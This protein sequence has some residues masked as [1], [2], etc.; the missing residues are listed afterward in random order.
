MTRSERT[1]ERTMNDFTEGTFSIRVRASDG[2]V[3]LAWSGKSTS[4]YPDRTLT[5]YLEEVIAEAHRA[6]QSLEIDLSAVEYVNSST[7]AAIIRALG[8]S[9]LR[10][11]HVVV[12]YDTSVASQKRNFDALR[13]LED[14]EL[15][16]SFRSTNAHDA[17]HGR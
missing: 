4:R 14:P 10:R 17:S 6:R 11:V 8:S 12:K 16:I 1:G 3:R 13:V 15:F 9:K 5:P 2:V 7:I